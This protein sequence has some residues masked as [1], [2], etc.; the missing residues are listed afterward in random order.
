MKSFRFGYSVR[1]R[2]PGV[3]ETPAA[4]GAKFLQTLDALNRI[5]PIF[6]DWH[7]I[8]CRARSGR[9]LATARPH[10]AALIEN[11]VYRDDWDNPNPHNGYAAVAKT[12]TSVDPRSM[13]ISINAGGKRAGDINLRAGEIGIPPDPAIVTYPVFKAALL[14]TNATWSP[15]WADAYAFEMGYWES[16]LV[17]GM[18][19]FPY[20]LFHMPWLAYLSAP[21]AAGVKL[22]NEILTE[23]TPDGGLLMVAAEERLDPTNPEHLRR[24]R[25]LAEIMIARTGERD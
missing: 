17:P 6:G 20:S 5:N 8:D 18:P 14:A 4:V 19:V 11:N 3:P 9:P 1:S 2:L 25:I 16:P 15:T 21:L 10:I 24:A 12:G 22:P 7:V 23:R 13:N